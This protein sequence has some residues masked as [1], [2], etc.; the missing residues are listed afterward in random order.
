[1]KRDKWR[2]GIW[3]FVTGGLVS[4]SWVAP[5]VWCLI[6][7][8]ASAGA[9]LALWAELRGERLL[10]I[11]GVGVEVQGRFFHKDAVQSVLLNEAIRTCDIVHYVLLRTNCGIVVPFRDRPP[12]LCQ[13]RRIRQVLREAC[14]LTHAVPEEEQELSK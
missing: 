5:T 10:C 7:L 11:D 8:T 1:M 6:L 3:I 9:S 2:L 14:L 13:L 12:C 4:L